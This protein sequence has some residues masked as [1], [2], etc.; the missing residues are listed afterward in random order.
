[1]YNYMFNNNFSMNVA[2]FVSL[3][4]APVGF[5]EITAG[6][7]GDVKTESTHSHGPKCVEP[8][9]KQT[10]SHRVKRLMTFT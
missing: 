9:R 10:Q 8:K 6:Y 5:L 2:A 3:K 7:F 1:M 4:A